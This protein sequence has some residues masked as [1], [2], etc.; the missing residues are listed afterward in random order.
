M[1]RRPRHLCA[2]LLLGMASVLS[3]N[4]LLINPSFDEP[5]FEVTTCDE[6]NL[7]PVPGWF[8]LEEVDG[9][10]LRTGPLAYR[11]GFV[12]TPDC[13]RDSD[14]DA[15]WI[16]AS[17]EFCDVGVRKG[18]EQ[19][20][21]QVT[22]GATLT[23]SG[24]WSLGN[25]GA[26]DFDPTTLNTAT[27]AFAYAELHEGPDGE[28]EPLVATMIAAPPN[29]V[30]NWQPFS[31]SSVVTGTVVTVRVW[32]ISGLGSCQEIGFHLDACVLTQ[33][34]PCNVPFADADGDGDVDG[35]DFAVFQRCYTGDGDGHPP[36]PARPAYCPCFN[37]EGDDDAI[38]GDDFEAFLN[39]VTGPMVLHATHPN[40]L[41]SD[42]P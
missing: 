26:P 13:P 38:A 3:A 4:N 12:Y 33:T 1:S 19:T 41:C 40:P 6:R 21:E 10:L 17:I 30:S 27:D 5:V 14:G 37:R 16:H 22:P 9:Q 25:S 2:V 36:I 39:C 32:I 20:V 11:N 29:S 34:V 15:D 24:W 28:G 35:T 8:R 31:I 7:A 23:F 18:I 42:Q